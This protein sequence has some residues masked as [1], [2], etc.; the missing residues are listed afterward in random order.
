MDFSQIL[1]H[2]KQIE[3][4]KGA[5]KNGTINHCYLFEGEKGLGK[6]NLALAFSKAI[7]CKDNKSPEPC[8]VCSSC[9]KFN[10]DNHPDFKLISP[11]KGV[12]KKDEIDKLIKGMATTPFEGNKKVFVIDSS[13]MIRID[14]QNRILKTLEEPPN[15]INIILITSNS[16]KLIPTILS[17]CQIIKFYP[18]RNSKIIDLLVKEYGLHIDKAKFIADFSKGSVEKSIELA[19][20][21]DFFQ[22]REETISIID[23]LLNG[24]KVKALT[25]MDFFNENKENI[26]EIL[27]IIIYWFRDLLIYKEIGETPVLTNNDKVEMLSRQSFIDFTRINDIIYKIEDTKN[28]IR[29]NVNFGL[30][31]E[32]MLLSI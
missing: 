4:L 27:D 18:I 14:G 12:I 23:S 13:D 9:I 25:S 8:N 16:T 10:A 2:E 3:S 30:S 24:D 15:Y 28:N 5:I 20:S 11:E 26:E 6:K 19:N 31:L 21:E 1:G 22:K 29:R 7:L 32:T 17:R